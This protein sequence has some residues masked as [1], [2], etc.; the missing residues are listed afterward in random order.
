MNDGM[1]GG[2]IIWIILAGF[3][4]GI[5]RRSGRSSL[6]I[7]PYQEAVLFKKGAYVKT[8]KPGNYKFTASR[9]R[10]DLV[11]MREESFSFHQNTLT[12]DNITFTVTISVKFQV[13]NAYKAISI[14]QNYKNTLFEDIRSVV[15]NSSGS[16]TTE[17]IVNDIKKLS[18]YIS[19]ESQIKAENLG[20]KLNRIEI[21]DLI[22]PPEIRQHLAK[23]ETKDTLN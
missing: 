9:Y 5:Y 12:A 3:F 20:I 8:L 15:R 7:K 21:V 10:A 18:E 19:R 16:F 14:S 23:S 22:L 6:V 11:D 2:I 17:Q 13:G 4:I 1:A